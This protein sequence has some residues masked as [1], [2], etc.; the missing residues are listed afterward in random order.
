MR[1]KFPSFSVRT[2]LETWFIM[3]LRHFFM[4]LLLCILN[5]INALVSEMAGN[6]VISILPEGIQVI[7]SY[8]TLAVFLFI[9]FPKLKSKKR[10]PEA[11]LSFTP[12]PEGRRTSNSAILMWGNFNSYTILLGQTMTW[13]SCKRWH[14]PF[15]CVAQGGLV[16]NHRLTLV[17]WLPY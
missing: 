6:F 9:W 14:S 15:K 1:R 7:A 13:K 2:H 3:H 16:I 4:A 5:L 8:V 12:Q 10:R 11:Q 17:T